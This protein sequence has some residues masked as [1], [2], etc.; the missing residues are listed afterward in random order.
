MSWR[1]APGPARILAATT[2]GGPSYRDCGI[3]AGGLDLK[4]AV[5]G[6][7]PFL[8]HLTEPISGL[9]PADLTAWQQRLQEAWETLVRHHRATAE[10]LAAGVSTL[11]PLAG[12]FARPRSLTSGWA[13]GAIGLTL[14]A[15][16]VSLA[17]TLVHELHHLILGAVEDIVPLG[18]D[19]SWLGYAPW[20]DDP[21][22]A[23]GLLHGC[24]AYL[25][26][27]AFWR[28]QRRVGTPAQR[29]RGAVEFARWRRAT[30][31]AARRLAASSAL[32]ETGTRFAGGICRQ[33]TGWQGA[34]VPAEA[35]ALAAEIRTEHR[36]RWRLANMRPTT[37]TI[38]VLARAWYSGEPASFREPDLVVAAEPVQL[39]GP[40][41]QLRAYLLQLRYRDPPQF[42]RLM[43]AVGDVPG[44]ATRAQSISEADA[45]LLR[46]EFE[47]AAQGYRR[48]LGAADDTDAWIGLAVAMTRFDDPAPTQLISER[49][50]VAAALLAR[51]RLLQQSTPDIGLLLNWLSEPFREHAEPR[52]I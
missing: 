37:D 30:L 27:T 5:D 33:L 1:C 22:P 16:G 48:R 42:S 7:D 34:A 38:D 32:T 44:C 26:V 45:A 2:L 46:G 11:I 41:A 29:L 36:V 35:E 39:A 12:T 51:L 6:C 50:D 24:Y 4:I 40:S 13:F 3:R 8:P 23:V 14:P 25:G 28:R 31:D 21:R 49:P 15:D 52:R 43:S 17:E 20:R 9:S 10:A 47:V 19:D 18:A